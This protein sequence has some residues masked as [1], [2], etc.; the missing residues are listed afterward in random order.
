MRFLPTSILAIFREG[1]QYSYKKPIS[2]VGAGDHYLAGRFFIFEG[3]Y[4]VFC[5]HEYT[6]FFGETASLIELVVNGQLMGFL[7]VAIK[8]M[9]FFWYTG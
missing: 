2:G 9:I 8:V 3:L 6:V 7:K 5:S 1:A 4:E